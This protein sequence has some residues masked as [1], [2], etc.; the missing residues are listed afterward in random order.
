ML[1]SNLDSELFKNFSVYTHDGKKLSVQGRLSG[2]ILVLVRKDISHFVT[3][4][5]IDTDNTL[6]FHVDKRA[7]EMEKDLMI[8]CTY[9][10]PYDSK[11]WQTS[12]H[13]FGIELLEK[14]LL[15]LHEKY[16]NFQFLICGDLNARTA[17][18]NV[19]L[20][21]E[22]DIEPDNVSNF[23]KDT[24][25]PRQ[26]DDQEINRFG[27]QLLE[28][29]G[30]F[31]CMILNGLSERQFD[32]GC[33]YV[34]QSGSSA[35]DYFIVSC[36]LY[37]DNLIKHFGI[38]AR[39]ESDHLPIRL[40]LGQ[41]LNHRLNTAVL[42]R[43]QDN[44]TKKVCWDKDKESH[45]VDCFQSESVQHDMQKAFS[46]LEDDV[47]SALNIFVDCLR[48]SSSCMIKESKTGTF[49]LRKKATW[50]DVECRNAK[51][52]ANCKLKLWRKTKTASDRQ[53][54]VVLRNRYRGI[55]KAKKKEYRKTL[56]N[57]L[58]TN[59]NNPSVFWKELKSLGGTTKAQPSLR[60]SLDEWFTHFRNVFSESEV[61]S[62]QQYTQ[63]SSDN[64]SD[65]EHVLNTPIKKEEV[66]HAIHKLNN[67]KSGGTDGVVPE[68]LKAGGQPVILFLHKLFNKLFEA[69]L[70]P[71]EWAKAIV[72]PVFKKGD[73]NNTD[74]YRGIS[75]LNIISKCYTSILNTRLYSWLEQD[76]KICEEQAG[77]R[78]NY[79]T[80]D[81]IFT[82]YSVVQKYLHKKGQKLYV[83]FVDFRKAFDSVKHDLLMQELYKEGVRGK[84]FNALV[85]MYKSLESCVKVNGVFSD[86]FKCPVG[87][88]QGCMISPTLFLVFINNLANHVKVNG[89]H[90]V[91]LLPGLLELYIL[92]FADDV[93][94]MSTT[95]FG[96]QH[97]LD[98]L[99]NCC[100]RLK[101]TV[102]QEKTKIM[103]FRKGGYLSKSERWYYKGNILEVVNKYCYLGFMFSTKLSAKIGTDHLV[104]KAKKASFFLLKVFFKC[105]DMSKDIFFKIF[106]AKVQSILL[107]SSEVW[108]ASKLQSIERVHMF[109]CKRFLNVPVKT[110]NA[111]VYGELGRQPLYIN[112]YVRCVKYWLHLQQ[113]D[114]SRLPRQAYEMLVNLDTLGKHCWVSDIKHILSQAGFSIVWLCQGVGDVASFLT[115]LK[116][117]LTDMYKQ[118]WC[119]I[120]RDK[121]RY[122]FYFTFKTLLECEKYFSFMD[123]SCFR[124]AFTQARTNSL[125]IN[126]NIHRYSDNICDKFCCCCKSIIEDEGHV[127][128]HCPL[129]R[130]VRQK[131]L[132]ECGQLPL[133]SLLGGFNTVVSKQISRFIFHAMNVRRKLFE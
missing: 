119:G 10:P 53:V 89:R 37:I 20:H 84:F 94:L 88:R 43:S 14:T 23:S 108:G 115:L 35:V 131:Y 116:Q 45:F 39:V 121:E 112:G 113:L 63:F 70:Y 96:L 6:I 28:F 47:D 26:S 32:G 73:S 109:V 61:P 120:I 17:S 77:F 117:R 66:I 87:V 3:K 72:V 41:N 50:F 95:T 57:T 65:D 118:E 79:S 68:M 74:N 8:V 46:M 81:H 48:S 110:P 56:V 54:Y 99:R 92:L 130:D 15:D 60:I 111:M 1:G 25:F 114:N 11:F 101:L 52:E 27:E 86:F 103:V 12:K 2:G 36:S 51:K 102:N 58:L 78:K 97:Q 9:L 100:D 21:S 107:Y 127:I 30:L 129:Y 49:N 133:Q 34:G 24:D 123:V 124:V 82:L 85:A 76:K 40:V 4:V 105:K 38:D 67:G 83:A 64:L 132:N 69:G 18:R 98:I 126:S 125:P 128:Y 80:T 29:C 75:L 104:S 55:I 90:G 42:N 22:D 106:D 31:E 59:V 7:I 16:D 13:G 122:S 5:D 93:V 71:R 19:L 44:V 91:Q 33:T 62:N